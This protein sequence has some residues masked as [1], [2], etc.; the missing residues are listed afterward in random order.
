MVLMVSM[1]W[2]LSTGMGGKFGPK[3]SL[4]F[5]QHSFS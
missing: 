4:L 1:N 3:Y 2:Q 5:I